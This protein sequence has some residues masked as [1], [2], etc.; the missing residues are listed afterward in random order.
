MGTRIRK[1]KPEGGHPVF[2]A[3]H[4]DADAVA[5]GLHVEIHCIIFTLYFYMIKKKSKSSGAVLSC[6]RKARC[7]G[8]CLVLLPTSNLSQSAAERM[9]KRHRLQENTE[10]S[11]LFK[12]VLV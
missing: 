1:H 6:H 4:R 3:Q 12:L 7:R 2:K 10:P 11:T 5:Q 9:K 8:N